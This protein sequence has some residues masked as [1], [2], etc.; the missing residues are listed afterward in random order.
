[1]TLKQ[2]IAF[3]FNDGVQQA[4]KRPSM[5]GYVYVRNDTPAPAEGDDAPEA[6]YKLVFVGRKG[7]A[8]VASVGRDPFD[9]KKVLGDAP[10]PLDAE[11]IN[12]FLADDWNVDALDELEKARSGQGWM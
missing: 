8:I 7:E 5:T 9:V 2:A 11:L 12:A 1:M 3:L 6:D 10:V 4:A